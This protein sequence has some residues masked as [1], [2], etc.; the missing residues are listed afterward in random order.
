MLG[1]C[2]APPGCDPT[3]RRQRGAC[4]G[5]KLVGFVQQMLRETPEG[6]VNGAT[7]LL[8][9][10]GRHGLSFLEHR[11]GVVINADVK[12]VLCYHPKHQ[13]VTEYAGLAEHP[14]HRDVAKWCE[15]LAQKL[16]KAVAR[17]HPRCSI[18]GSGM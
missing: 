9:V 4:P 13:P 18:M 5:K 12:R 6:E 10:E 7:L 8:V 3:C 16:G 2:P 11:P 1:G 17:D 15:L 14:S